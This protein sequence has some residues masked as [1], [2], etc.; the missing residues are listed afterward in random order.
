MPYSCSALNLDMECVL[1][2]QNP[3]V[4]FC[5]L[6]H[7]LGEKGQTLIDSVLFKTSLLSISLK[8]FVLGSREGWFHHHNTTSFF[9]SLLILA[10]HHRNILKFKVTLI[11]FSY[12]V[13]F[14][15]KQQVRDKRNCRHEN[16]WLCLILLSSLSSQLPSSLM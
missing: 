5:T 10:V 8:F 9:S 13:V 7:I 2:V 15:E 12:D 3:R 1:C 6:L 16:Q 4:F 14:L 11:L